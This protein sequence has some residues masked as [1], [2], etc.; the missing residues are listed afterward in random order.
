MAEQTL[1]E[2]IAR[3]GLSAEVDGADS[4]P[5]MDDMP[6]GSSHWLVTIRKDDES[7]DVPFSMGPALN[8]PPTLASV[9]NCLASDAASVDN[10][11]SFDEWAEEMGYF[12]MESSE[13]FRKA[14]ST[15]KAIEQQSSALRDLLGHEAFESLLYET[16]RL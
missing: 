13:D 10:A 8:G 1:Q 3:E 14:E 15:Y 9:L 16:E 11:R 12:P 7:M 6:V 4:N 2:F 5:N